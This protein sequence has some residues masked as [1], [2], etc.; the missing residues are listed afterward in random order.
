[1]VL[2]LASF[3]L[4]VNS[5]KDIPE[6]VQISR[7]EW[8]TWT[9]KGVAA[10]VLAW[11]LPE[12]FAAEPDLNKPSHNPGKIPFSLII[13]DGSPVDPLFYELPGYETPY[14]I[15]AD[16]IKRVADTFDQFDLRGKFTV[17]PMPSCLGRLDQ[18]LNRVPAENQANFIKIVRERFAP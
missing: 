10:G 5:R 4:R 15:P 14:L 7:R 11:H 2:A 17:I 3:S 12:I 16:F 18:T 9:S 13:D 6:G 1:M 8:L